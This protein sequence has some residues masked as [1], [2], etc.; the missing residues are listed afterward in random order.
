MGYGTYMAF[1]VVNAI[2]VLVIVAFIASYLFNTAME[3]ELIASIQESVR[4]EVMQ[5]V[6]ENPG[7][8]K[9]QIQAY[10][11]LRLQEEYRRFGL[12]QPYVVRVF[13]RAISVIRFDLGKSKGAIKSFSTQSRDVATILLEALPNTILLFTTGTVIT[14]IIGIYLGFRAARNVGSLFDRALSAVAM[15][16]YSLPMWWT[17]MMMIYLFCYQLPHSFSIP[18]EWVLPH[19]GIVDTPVPREP[20]A[21]VASVLR[22]MILP[23]STLVLVS[24]GGYAYVTRSVVLGIMQQDFVMAARAKGLPE[25]KVIYGHVLRTASPSIVTMSILSLLSSLGGAIITEA[26]FSWPGMGTLYWMSLWNGEVA[27]LLGLTYITTLLYLISMVAADL[28][29]GL[30]DPRVRVGIMAKG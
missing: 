7:V 28:I 19:A 17:G 14:I 15:V 6:K 24:F 16:T 4:A 27:V 9:E 12:D 1:R 21:Y 26:V 8:T 10:Y 11:Q 25:R 30:L 22:H 20:L 13:R 23:V 3:K 18:P 29:Y 5:W 2:V